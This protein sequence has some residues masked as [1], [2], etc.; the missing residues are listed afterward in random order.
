CRH[1]RR[2]GGRDG[3]PGRAPPGAARGARRC[4]RDAVGGLMLLAY[5]TRNLL[6]RRRSV[7]PPLLAVAA[8]G[9]NAPSLRAGEGGPRET[10]VATGSPDNAVVIQHGQMGPLDGT[11]ALPAL[12]SIQIAPGIAKSDGKPLVSAE[13]LT[14][15]G[16]RT[17]G[18]SRAQL[19]FR[20]VEPVALAV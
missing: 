13:Y 6:A 2:R 4:R 10:M 18:V 9:G 5:T 1:Q 19:V 17:Q 16:I 3:R 8:A 15:I 7:L 20:G 14:M 12:A 11:I